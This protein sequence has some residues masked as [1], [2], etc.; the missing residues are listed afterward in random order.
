LGPAYPAL[1]W[2][3]H[4]SFALNSE[5]L[6]RDWNSICFFYYVTRR[7]LLST[8]VVT[9]H[10]NRALEAP[11]AFPIGPTVG[12]ILVV[13]DQKLVREVTSEVL[14]RV[15]YSVVTAAT[16]AEAQQRFASLAGNVALVITDVL[17]PDTKGTALADTLCRLSPQLQVILTSGYPGKETEGCAE[18]QRAWFMAKP[19]SAEILLETVQRVLDCANSRSLAASASATR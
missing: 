15:G 7:W 19:Y 16:A 13:E 1:T 4:K 8:N 2:G 3:T 12:N 10:G 14:R 18:S 17:L 11:S 5:E 9:G 6:Q